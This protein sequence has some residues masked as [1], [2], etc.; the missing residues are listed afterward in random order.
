MMRLSDR[1]CVITGAANGI[2]QAC[3][4][5][6]AQEGGKVVVADIDQDGGNRVVYEIRHA[7]GTAVFQPTDVSDALQLEALLERSL[8]EFNGFYRWR[9]S[10]DLARWGG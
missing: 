5:R 7:G 10:S 8:S 2:G 9:I 3:A 4:K 6:Y 1:V